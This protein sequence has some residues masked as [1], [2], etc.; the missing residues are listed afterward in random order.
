MQ[1]LQGRSEEAYQTVGKARKVSE[2][3]DTLYDAARFAAKTGRK[4]ESLKLIDR[5]I[6]LRPT[7]IVTIFSESDF[8]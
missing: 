2:D 1:D 5:C 6:D 8:L 4:E 3:H 7:T